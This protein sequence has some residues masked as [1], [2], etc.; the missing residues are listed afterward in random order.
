M[1]WT[2]RSVRPRVVKI[3]RPVQDNKKS[4]IFRPIQRESFFHLFHPGNQ[5]GLQL[6]RLYFQS[7]ELM[8]HSLVG[9]GQMKQLQ[10]HTKYQPLLT[11]LHLRLFVHVDVNSVFKDLDWNCWLGDLFSLEKLPSNMSVGDCVD[12]SLMGLLRSPLFRRCA[13]SKLTADTNFQR[14]VGIYWINIELQAVTYPIR[15]STY[16]SADTLTWQLSTTKAHA[17]PLPYLLPCYWLHNLQCH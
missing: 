3:G 8:G 6:S 14:L 15:A 7:W 13:K 5:E 1:A 2:Y 9:K 16:M 4:F 10:I 12:G 11:M 17:W